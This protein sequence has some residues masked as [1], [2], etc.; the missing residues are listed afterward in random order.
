MAIAND[1]VGKLVLRVV[2][3]VTILLH[4]IGKILHGI[5]FIEQTVQAAGLPA[6]LAYGVYVG[7]VI[8]PLMVITGMY[9]RIG[10]AIIAINMAVALFLV[11]AGELLTLNDQGGW[12][13]EL[14]VLMLF[15]AVAIAFMGPGKFA[16]NQK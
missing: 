12:A 1:S 4:G 9:A 16:F 2:L 5:D 6:A 14:Q 3:G 15:S 13:I 8:A 11:H 7:E 10:A